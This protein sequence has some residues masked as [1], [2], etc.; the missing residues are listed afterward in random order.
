MRQSPW[1]TA[2]DRDSWHRRKKLTTHYRQAGYD[3]AVAAELPPMQ[4]AHV[5]FYVTYGNNRRLDPCNYYLTVKAVVDGMVDMGWLPDD[6]SRH[7]IGPDPRRDESLSKGVTLHVV[8]L[9]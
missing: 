5:V 4:K 9:E 7:L 3:A 6:D 1:L 8:R 2:N